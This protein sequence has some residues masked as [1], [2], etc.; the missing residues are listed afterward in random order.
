MKTKNLFR[1]I[2]AVAF[3][4][5]A[6]CSSAPKSESET[7]P[8][9]EEKAKVKVESVH[10]QDVEQLHEFTA[11]VQ[12]EVNNKIAPQS[13]VRIQ[14]LHVEIGDHVTKGQLLAT[15]DATNLTQSKIQIENQETEFKRID[16]LYK[17]GGVSK[18]TWDAQRTA[19]S[20][21]KETYRNLQENNQ[22]LSPI[23]GVVTARNYDNGDMYSG[24]QPVYVVQQIRPVKLIINVSESFYKNVK[25]GMEVV[26]RLDVY[27]EEKFPGTVSLVYPTIDES[28]RTFPVEIKINNSDERVRPGMFARVTMNFG[29]IQRVVIPDLAVVKQAGSG[30]KY[31]YIYKNGK[32]SYQKIELGRRLDNRYE[33]LSGV[34]NGEQ[35]VVTGQ[36]RLMEGTEVEVIK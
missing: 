19:L 18:S 31:V 4:A 24:A 22:L 5:L 3:A 9:V 7:A 35:V 28:S 30:D 21:A 6:S 33:L 2:P 12:A 32:V 34:E 11:T 13:P 29:T 8:V 25:R 1:L 36:S 26:V 16:E 20:V 14:K 17:V 23:T 15:M 27:G 10:T